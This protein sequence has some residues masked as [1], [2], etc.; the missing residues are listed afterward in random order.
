MGGLARPFTRPFNRP[1]IRLFNRPFNLHFNHLLTKT[2]DRPA[3]A[4]R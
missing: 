1:F 2:A 4:S 3:A